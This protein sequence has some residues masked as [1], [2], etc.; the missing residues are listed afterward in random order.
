[1]R[2][3]SVLDIGAWDGFYSFEAERRGAARVVALDKYV[4]ALDWDA[5][6]IY[7]GECKKQGVLPQPYHLVP[8]VW[9]FD[10]LPGQ[11]GFKIAHEVLQSRVETVVGDLM[12]I[13]LQ[14]FGQFDIVFYLG[15]L[16]HV[17]NP[18]AALQRLRQVTKQVAIIE[19]EAAHFGGFETTP[20]CEFFPTKAKLGNDPTNFWAPNAPALVSLCE[21]AGFRKV[22]L[23]TAPPLA[24]KGISRYRL[25]AHAFV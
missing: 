6:R 3:K 24:A 18:L 5:K 23:L 8:E 21:A 7:H 11:R 25:I 22:Q 10:E 16:Y 13:D 4:W 1:M 20:L 14:T 2:G 15:V 17:E 9:R 12:T 19:T